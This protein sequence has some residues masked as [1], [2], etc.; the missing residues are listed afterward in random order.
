MLN[1]GREREQRQ[2]TEE[3]NMYNIAMRSKKF[4]EER[5]RKTNFDVRARVEACTCAYVYEFLAWSMINL[6]TVPRCALGC[7]VMTEF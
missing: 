4:G 6:G 3:R 1:R 5:E 7:C 2:S